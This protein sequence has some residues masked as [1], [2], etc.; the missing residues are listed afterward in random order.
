MIAEIPGWFV[1]AK[2]SAK[3]LLVVEPLPPAKITPR[4]KAFV[5]WLATIPA[6]GLVVKNGKIKPLDERIA[7]LKAA[8]KKHVNEYKSVKTAAEKN[9][10][11]FAVKGL[12]RGLWLH[13]KALDIQSKKRK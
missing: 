11:M 7:N 8:I 4:Q 1:T 3:S 2:E 10:Q 6:E 5:Q 12:R 13:L 9:G